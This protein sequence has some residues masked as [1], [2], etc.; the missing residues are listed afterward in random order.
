MIKIYN[1][2]LKKLNHLLIKIFKP[3]II[4][5]FIP[6]NINMYKKIIKLTKL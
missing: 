2:Q 5:K 1:L 4:N 3:Q 6:L